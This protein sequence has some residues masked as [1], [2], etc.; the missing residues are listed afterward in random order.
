MPQQYQLTPAGHTDLRL[1]HW[2]EQRRRA[3][4]MTAVTA[5]T[6]MPAEIRNILRRITSATSHNEQELMV[7]IKETDPWVLAYRLDTTPM[8]QRNA[9]MSHTER[10]RHWVTRSHPSFVRLIRE[11]DIKAENASMKAPP[12]FERSYKR[13]V[14]GLMEGIIQCVQLHPYNVIMTDPRYYTLRFSLLINEQQVLSREAVPIHPFAAYE[15]QEYWR[16]R[17][18]LVLQA[19]LMP[20]AAADFADLVITPDMSYALSHFWHLRHWT[21]EMYQEVRDRELNTVRWRVLFKS[22]A[23]QL[24]PKERYEAAC[25][26]KPEELRDLEMYYTT[27]NSMWGRA[28]PDQGAMP[29]RPVWTGESDASWGN[30][31]ITPYKISGHMAEAQRNQVLTLDRTTDCI[32]YNWLY[33]E[34]ATLLAQ[35]A[36]RAARSQLKLESNEA[37]LKYLDENVNQ[38]RYMWHGVNLG[39]IPPVDYTRPPHRLELV[40]GGPYWAATPTAPAP[41]PG[42]PVPP[43]SSTANTTTP[44]PGNI[45][46]D[47]SSPAPAGPAPA[48]VPLPVPGPTEPTNPQAPAGSVTATTQDAPAQATPTV[49]GESLPGGK[50]SAPTHTHPASPATAGA[51]PPAP[52][53][54]NVGEYSI[55]ITHTA[56]PSHASEADATY[57]HSDDVHMDT[58][59]TAA[60]TTAVVPPPALVSTV[61]SAAE[62]ASLA[63]SALASEEILPQIINIASSPSAGG[64]ETRKRMRDADASPPAAAVTAAPPTATIISPTSPPQLRSELEPQDDALMGDGADIDRSAMDDQASGANIGNPPA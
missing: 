60:E 46:A 61:A 47:G 43:V 1:R 40:T 58:E 44:S 15:R 64:S 8:E 26:L 18:E 62:A 6:R 36:C 4:E 24:G 22:G 57:T 25:L 52:K 34:H 19:R 27:T 17:L 23:D 11:Q 53:V 49:N 48:P 9:Y 21:S 29:D 7:L 16:Q 28:R 30:H 37:L 31:T 5:L 54:I 42:T 14:V 38:G 20:R 59:H 56:S 50:P 51:A 35:A 2:Y 33:A 3:K 55:P 10:F 13:L 32:A 45:P 63:V 41:P 39:D 12:L